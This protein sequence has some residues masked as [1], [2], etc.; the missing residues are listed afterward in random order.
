MAQP[1]EEKH[2]T[3][4]PKES[5]TRPDAFLDELE[6]VIRQDS[7]DLFSKLLPGLDAPLEELKQGFS[8]LK[9]DIE[10]LT[11]EPPKSST[12]PT[13]YRAKAVDLFQQWRKKF[14]NALTALLLHSKYRLI[15]ILSE[16]PKKIVSLLKGIALHIKQ[17]IDI[18][19][20]WSRKRKILFCLA[21]LALTGILYFYVITIKSKALYRD[22]FYFYGS[23]REL[24]DFSFSHDPKSLLEPFYTSPRVKSYSFQMKPVVVNLKRRNL[25][26]DNPMGFFEFVFVGN[27]GDVVI[28]MKSRESEFIDL[29]ERVIEDHNY[30]T[31][32]TPEGKRN[33]KEDLRRELNARLNEGFIRTIE[34]RNFFIKP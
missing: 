18:F 9:V 8:E 13:H 2:K 27:S 33:L 28:E 22:G 14:S 4:H 19:K 16:A 21:L 17:A 15:K 10:S 31:L 29:T 24:S 7:N 5:P 20:Q 32:D 30:E 1:A 6:G 3:H 12:K 25:E 34:I 11:I 26:K 23:M